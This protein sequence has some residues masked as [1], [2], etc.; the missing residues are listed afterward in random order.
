[1]PTRRSQTIVADVPPGVVWQVLQT[2][3]DPDHWEDPGNWGDFLARQ[4]IDRIDVIENDPLTG[5][6]QIDFKK[7]ILLQHQSLVAIG[8]AVAPQGATNVNGSIVELWAGLERTIP[9]IGGRLERFL[10]SVSVSL[11]TELS[12]ARD[13]G[14]LRANQWQPP[15]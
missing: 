5:S 14:L 8:A 9:F 2:W 6:F 10:N 13:T 12:E 1:M 15:V 3:I 4:Y 7:K 11:E